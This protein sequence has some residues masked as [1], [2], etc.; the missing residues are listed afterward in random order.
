MIFSGVIVRGYAL[1]VFGHLKTKRFTKAK[2]P[3]TILFMWWKIQQK[4][5]LFEFLEGSVV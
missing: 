5:V 4:W 3:I 1:F 2:K